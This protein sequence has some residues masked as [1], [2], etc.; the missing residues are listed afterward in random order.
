[1][2][3]WLPLATAAVL[4]SLVSAGADDIGKK[5]VDP[6]SMKPVTVAKDTPTV[7]VNSNHL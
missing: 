1:M 3:F 4:G 5:F 7:V 6:V 2:R